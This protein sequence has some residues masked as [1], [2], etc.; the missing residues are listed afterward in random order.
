MPPFLSKVD[1]SNSAWSR[2]AE[3][4]GQP[5]GTQVKQKSQSWVQEASP[6]RST[7][8]VPPRIHSVTQSSTRQILITHPLWVRHC[9]A[10]LNQRKRTGTTPASTCLSH[11][12]V[13]PSLVS[14]P[15]LPAPSVPG[16]V[17]PGLWHDH[18]R[19]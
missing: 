7:T 11:P 19:V 1:S 4:G 16:R 2:D 6:A 12:Q 13:V 8:E 3:R 9:Q 5:R 14:S 18:L 10:Q 15:L 17:L